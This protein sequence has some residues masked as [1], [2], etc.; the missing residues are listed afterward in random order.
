[1]KQKISVKKTVKNHQHHMQKQLPTKK[2]Q[3]GKRKQALINKNNGKKSHVENTA[4]KK[5]NTGKQTKSHFITISD[6]K[7]LTYY[8][9]MNIESGKMGK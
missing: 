5:C 6:Q 9:S 2:K 1:M 3:K 7:T 8:Y 4:S